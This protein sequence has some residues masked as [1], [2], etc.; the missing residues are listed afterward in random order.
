LK[1]KLNC[2]GVRADCNT[3]GGVTAAG[4]TCGGV[5]SRRGEVFGASW[6]DI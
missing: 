6:I 4:R 3:R 1:K 5:A 2:A